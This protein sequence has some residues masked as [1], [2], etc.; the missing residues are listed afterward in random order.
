V[1]CAV[2]C[3]GSSEEAVK[4]VLVD[5][6]PVH[7]HGL[8]IDP[9]DG[10]LFVATHTGLFRV[11]EGETKATRIA[12]RYQDTLGFTIVA[13]DRFLGSGHAD[14]KEAREK[15]WPPLLG[16]IESRDHGNSWTSISLLGEADIHVLRSSGD[17]VYGFDRRT[18]A[19][20]SATKPARAGWSARCPDFHRSR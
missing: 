10:S 7:V 12:G 3:G 17:R 2:G 1:R 4:P 5:P 20:S 15:S 8:G 6:G 16:S 19:C 11:E 9:A 14:L 13:A 18:I